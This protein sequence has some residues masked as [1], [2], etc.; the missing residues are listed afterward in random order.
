[1]TEP[2]LA[3]PWTLDVPVLLPAG[4]IARD[5]AGHAWWR[6][7]DGATTLPLAGDAEGLLCGT[8]LTRTAAIW[9]GNRLTILAALSSWGRID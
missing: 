3:E 2:L 8:D 5:D 1:L 7:A 9:S 4:R 6:S